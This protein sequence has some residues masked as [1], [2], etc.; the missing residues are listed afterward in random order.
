MMNKLFGASQ[1]KKEPEALNPNAPTLTETSSKVSHYLYSSNRKKF[2]VRRK[3]RC[4]SK[5]S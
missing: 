3:R 2:K 5:K 4:C 1:K